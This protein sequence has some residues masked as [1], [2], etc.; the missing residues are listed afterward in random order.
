MAPRCSRTSEGSVTE[1]FGQI[2]KTSS[3]HFNPSIAAAASE[4]S[5]D[6]FFC[7]VSLMDS[8]LSPGRC[9]NLN[10]KRSQ[11]HSKTKICTQSPHIFQGST[12]QIGP[13]NWRISTPSTEF[14]V[15]CYLAKLPAEHLL[16]SLGMSR[17]L[18]ELSR[19]TSKYG[20]QS[21]HHHQMLVLGAGSQSRL[22]RSVIK[23]HEEPS[24]GTR[25]GI[26]DVR[27]RLHK[28]KK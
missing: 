20:L 28:K 26:R 1:P 16:E 4:S 23:H 15:P 8:K 2:S 14:P 27:Q 6:F 17:N 5:G 24:G 21:F 25:Q 13:R 12:L 9:S 11:R 10:G 18:S 3:K 7:N 22:G 19:P